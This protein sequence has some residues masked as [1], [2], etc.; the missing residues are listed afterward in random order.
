MPKAQLPRAVPEG[1]A[2]FKL[3]A[4]LVQICVIYD[5][6]AAF[7]GPCL[8]SLLKNPN[9]LLID[10]FVIPRGVPLESIQ[11]ILVARVQVLQTD[12]DVGRSIP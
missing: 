12:L 11:A 10:C 6:Q 8:A 4:G 9:A 3:L 1:G 2:P 5:Q 7:Y